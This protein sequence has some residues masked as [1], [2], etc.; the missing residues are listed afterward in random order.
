MDKCA[1]QVQAMRESRLLKRATELRKRN[2]PTASLPQSEPT[3]STIQNT[4]CVLT[5]ENVEGPYYINN[6]LIRH[7]LR[8]DQEG[9]ELRFDIGVI[10][11]STC[12]PLENAFVELWM[13]NATGFYSGYGGSNQQSSSGGAPAGDEASLASSSPGDSMT[14]A[15]LSHASGSMPTGSPGGTGGSGGGN[16]ALANQETWLRGGYPTN[17]AGIVE[18]TSVFPGFYTGR[19]VHTHVM[20]HYN[21]SVNDNMTLISHSGS[22]LHVGQIFFDTNLTDS[23]MAVKPYT[24]NTNTRTYNDDDSLITQGW[25]DGNDPI[26]H[27]QLLGDAIEDGILGY[28]TLGVDTT[29]SYSI[30]NTNYAS[31][32]DAEVLAAATAGVSGGNP[33]VNRTTAT[34]TASGSTSAV[35]TKTGSS[36][37]LVSGGERSMAAPFALAIGSVLAAVLL[38]Q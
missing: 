38:N 21:Y 35:T 27:T 16:A 12:Q 22:L 36:S 11:V 15:A 18:L 2:Y 19:T 29:A 7:D 26:L 30:T 34:A 14:V 23:V 8:E 24:E 17:S 20:V 3:L 13:A 4:S 5:V 32:I 10:D 31:V 9:V 33:D 37:H 28:I 1:P 25:A 6:E